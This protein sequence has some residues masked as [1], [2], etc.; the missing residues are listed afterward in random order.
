MEKKHLG[1][2]IAI[3]ILVVTILAL[4]TFI[5]YDLIKGE[6]TVI[7]EEVVDVSETDLYSEGV[8]STTFIVNGKLYIVEIKYNENFEYLETQKVDSI[9]GTVKKV[10]GYCLG[11]SAT[12]THCAITTEGKVYALATSEYVEEYEPFS[13]Y[14]V[15][16][17]I[18]MEV[19]EY[20]DE[21]KILL[22]DGRKIQINI[23]RDNSTGEKQVTTK[24][25]Q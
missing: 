15:E 18:S 4:G 7:N 19:T 24:E 12:I 14:A 11:S 16:D 20:A 8:E 6:N 5:V 21:Y 22:K 25:I 2:K 13:D 17:I 3:A 10:K 1:F 9:P 23:V